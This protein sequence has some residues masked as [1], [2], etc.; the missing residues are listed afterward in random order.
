MGRPGEQQEA[1]WGRGEIQED[2]QNVTPERVCV[3]DLRAG[4]AALPNATT[5]PVHRTP[6]HPAPAALAQWHTVARVMYAH[7]DICIP[8]R[9]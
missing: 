8:P 1:L 5:L 6:I 3:C 4:P 9:A 7:R 2:S